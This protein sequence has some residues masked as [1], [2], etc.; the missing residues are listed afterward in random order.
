M[1]WKLSCVHISKYLSYTEELL[2]NHD[3]LHI[4]VLHRKKGHIL[5]TEDDH[6]GKL[7]TE[8]IGHSGV[9]T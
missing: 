5:L 2:V 7:K 8:I 1:E 9:S 3:V 4:T 6:Y